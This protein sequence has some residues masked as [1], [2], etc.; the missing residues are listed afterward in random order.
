M[1]IIWYINFIINSLQS[2]KK[3][4]S[5]ILI[6]IAQINIAI[7][8]LIFLLILS[9]GVGI[10]KNIKEHLLDFNGHFIIR[11]SNYNK[12]SLIEGSI[13]LNELKKCNKIA[14]IQKYALTLGVIRNE[15]VIEGLILKGV[16]SDFDILRFKKF[17]IQ[18]SFPNY[19][20]NIT[21]EDVVLSYKIAHNLNLKINNS[22]FIYFIN[23]NKDIIY[24]KFIIKGLFKT[25][26]K[27]F[28]E[29]YIIVNIEQVK[30]INKWK[31][32]EISGY[33]VFINEIENLDQITPILSSF[34]GSKN[35]IE[36][37]TIKYKE[38]I[39]W[40]NLFDI[41]IYILISIMLII[42]LI[43]VIIILFIIILE[44]S[45]FIGI[46]KV[47]G[48]NNFQLSIICIFHTFL[49]LIPG[50]LIGNLLA[51]FL[52]KIQEIF[53]I[54]KFNPEYYFFDYL[55]VYYNLSYFIFISIILLLINFIILLFCS[56]ITIKLK[57]LEIIRFS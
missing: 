51:Y 19:Y 40:I 2:S 15:K 26:I 36:K 45:F 29:N 48:M 25:N 55:P 49:I 57:P 12:T 22:F 44:K 46:M 41:N 27:N 5:K 23:H 32:N 38:I 39:D 52:I 11:N 1:N 47:L 28:D 30:N 56:Y 53:K 17:L 34:I 37:S 21:S 8:V 9:I 4:L 14:H 6:L 54:I 13:N 10:K 16:T 35:I 24:R 50:L 42:V 43:N 20:N 33:E 18:G 7:G 3:N 31:K